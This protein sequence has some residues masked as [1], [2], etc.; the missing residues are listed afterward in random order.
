MMCTVVL[1]KFTVGYFCVK[2]VYGKIF[3]FLGV[4]EEKIQ[5]NNCFSGQT[6]FLLLTNLIHNYT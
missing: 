5:T 3:M 1:E 6:F 2:I 4:F